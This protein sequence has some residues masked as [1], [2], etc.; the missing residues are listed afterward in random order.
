MVAA[1]IYTVLITRLNS[2][3]MTIASQNV[4][5]ECQNLMSRSG[6][7]DTQFTYY[8][9]PTT[10]TLWIKGEAAPGYIVLRR[11]KRKCHLRAK[12]FTFRRTVSVDLAGQ[13][14]GIYVLTITSG[15]GTSSY[16]IVKQ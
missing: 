16:H 7:T 15:L 12:S 10:G 1:G 3:C 13:P 14:A 2:N 4:L 9:N 8:P 5:D 11:P 6:E